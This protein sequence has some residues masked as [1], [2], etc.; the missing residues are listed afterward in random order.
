MD[1]PVSYINL[2][3]FFDSSPIFIFS[4]CVQI[5]ALYHAHGTVHNYYLQSLSA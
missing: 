5:Y 2:I 3:T 1:L 4:L